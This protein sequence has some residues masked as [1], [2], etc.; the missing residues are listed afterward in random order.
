MELVCVFEWLLGR[1]N[2]KM[3]LAL[4]VQLMRA[5]WRYVK[6]QDGMV[7]DKSVSVRRSQPD[8]I[9]MYVNASVSSHKCATRAGGR[10]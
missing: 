6:G 5:H 1:A 7:L 2:H 10:G 4:V 3:A 8:V 9:I